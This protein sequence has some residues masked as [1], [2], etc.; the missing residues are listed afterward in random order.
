MNEHYR[1][2]NITSLQFLV[3]VRVMFDRLRLGS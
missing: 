2:L 1:L 3:S